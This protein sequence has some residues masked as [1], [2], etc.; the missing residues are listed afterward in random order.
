M[1]DLQTLFHNPESL[2][3]R[4]LSSIKNHMRLQ[5]MFPLVTAA[6]FGAS[7]FLLDTRVFRKSHC[8]MRVGLLS[9]VGFFWGLERATSLFN[10]RAPKGFSE[11]ASDNFDAE[12]MGAFEDR[13]VAR[14]LNAAGYGNNALNLAS[15]T[16]DQTASYRKP[17]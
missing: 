2:S 5:R 1:A 3:D 12:I 9:T 8:F 11:V 17:Y 14:S 6:G 15:H 13:Y 4:D 7:M 10:N 16:K